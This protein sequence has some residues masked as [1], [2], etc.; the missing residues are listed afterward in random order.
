MTHYFLYIETIKVQTYQFTIQAHIFEYHANLLKWA[1]SLNMSSQTMHTYSK[2][3]IFKFV[4]N[5]TRPNPY[6]VV[7]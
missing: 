3:S 6:I 5:G 1:T 4:L 7:M 2:L